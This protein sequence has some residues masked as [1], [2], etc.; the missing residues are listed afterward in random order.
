LAIGFFGIILLFATTGFISIKLSQ[1]INSNVNQLTGKY[2]D[3]SDF[4]METRIKLGEVNK[5]VLSPPPGLDVDKFK[6]STTEFFED[7]IQATKNSALSSGVIDAIGLEII[8]VKDA[9][10][11]PLQLY[12]LPRE[13]ME[14]AD[15]AAKPLLDKV[16]AIGDIELEDFI[17]ESV[18][19]FNDFLINHDTSER[20][21]FEEITGI[22]KKHLQFSTFE[23]EYNQYE[24]KAFGVFGAAIDLANAQQA[25]VDKIS[26]LSETLKSTEDIFKTE[27]LIPKTEATR[28]I[29]S[30]S[31]QSI[32]IGLVLAVAI[33][34]LVSFFI[35]R[36]ISTPLKEA[37]RIIGKIGQGD[38]SEQLAVGI[39]VNCSSIKKCNEVNC[40][41]YGKTDVCWVNSGSFSVIKHCPRAKR[42]E[43]C[44]SCNLYGARTEMEELGSILAGLENFLSDREEI[45]S[46]IANGEFT[47]EVQVASEKDTFGR[48][49]KTMT[50]NLREIIS[51]VKGSAGQISSAAVQVSGA[52]QTLSQGATEQASSL[53][54]I[55]SSFNEIASQTK[56]NAENAHQANNF[57]NQ[58]KKA[59]DK[60][61]IQMQEMVS[62]INEINESG[63]SISKIIKVIDEI[64]FQTNLLALN[65]AVEAARA[66]KHGK[67]FAVVAEEVRNLAARSAKAA[68]ETAELI[69]GSVQK[70]QNGSETAQE[71]A[72]AL[73]EIVQS[74]NE[75]T[76]LVNRIA[77]ASNQQA[78]GISQI[79]EGLAQID[80]VTQKNTA[81][82]EESAAAAEE[83]SAQSL[84]LTELLS[85]FKLKSVNTLHFE[86]QISDKQ[87]PML[88]NM[89]TSPG[90]EEQQEQ[91]FDR[92]PN[93][94]IDLDAREFGKY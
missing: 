33:A 52:S 62:A 8:S 66:G 84:Q 34:L 18:M 14:D 81:H 64:A 92:D 79:N 39:R 56:I 6:K 57:S 53:E 38:L 46:Q 16:K 78:L 65:A 25:F 36:S 27:I 63:K 48:A 1:Q 26:I 55:S 10:T 32:L 82:A 42:G 58:A 45:A 30:K 12:S 93:Q 23:K 80:Q 29:V 67:G 40:P 24:A 54:E 35:S 21:R 85:R 49:F 51:Q 4:L 60:G 50:H 69:E 94:F 83:L 11:Y 17:W 73:E 43:D 77:A 20:R 90:Y 72:A 86:K 13:R 37:I 88:E 3:T 41:S 76:K 59:A 70:T 75:A 74:I 71:S 89:K 61:N 87:Q 2:W 15:I 19:T 28:G 91:L 7:S 22:I 44:R 68:R 47:N 5:V 31:Q 9:F